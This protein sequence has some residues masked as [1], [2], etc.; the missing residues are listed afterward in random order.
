MKKTI[1][2]FTLL[3]SAQLMFGQLVSKVPTSNTLQ[4]LKIQKSANGQMTTQLKDGTT[5]TVY[6]TKSRTLSA[7]RYKVS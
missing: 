1:S 3:I 4:G 6:W 2:I 7:G 5:A